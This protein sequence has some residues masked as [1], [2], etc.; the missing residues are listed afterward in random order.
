MCMLKN[1]K[2]IAVEMCHVHVSRDSMM[3]SYI[4]TSD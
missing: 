1:N 4:F 3:C 2:F